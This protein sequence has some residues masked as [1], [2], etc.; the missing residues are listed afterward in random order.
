MVA[1]VVVVVDVVVVA[2]AVAEF[3]LHPSAT[4]M[5][6]FQGNLSWQVPGATMRI[7]SN[8]TGPDSEMQARS[9]TEPEKATELTTDH[10][11]GIFLAHTLLLLHNFN[12]SNHYYYFYLHIPYFSFPTLLVLH[13][14]VKKEVYFTPTCMIKCA[15]YSHFND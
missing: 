5:Q 1:E 11:S 4:H 12:F 3:S 10:H 7:W 6:Y 9:L 2:V 15:L 8:R 13:I 14:S